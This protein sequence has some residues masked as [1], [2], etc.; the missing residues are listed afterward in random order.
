MP[1]KAHETLFALK[2]LNDYLRKLLDD[3]RKRKRKPKPKRPK[4]KPPKRRPGRAGGPVWVPGSGQAETQVL[5]DVGGR[6]QIGDKPSP[7]GKPCKLTGSDV[8]AIRS[9]LECKC[10]KGDSSAC[11]AASRLKAKPPN[12]GGGGGGGF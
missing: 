10:R 5:V 9:Y 11:A 3:L 4:R 8:F 7:G 2:V 12:S 1:D 6:P